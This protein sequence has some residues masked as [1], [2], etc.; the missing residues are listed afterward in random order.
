MSEANSSSL[1]YVGLHMKKNVL[2]ELYSRTSAQEHSFIPGPD[3]N[4]EILEPEPN[5]T[6]G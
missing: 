3:F 4:D 6:I 1:W 2:K 5:A